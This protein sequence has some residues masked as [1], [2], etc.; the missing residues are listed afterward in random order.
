[1]VVILNRISAAIPPP[2]APGSHGGSRTGAAG[3]GL[4]EWCGAC[5]EV[6]IE[7]VG[8]ADG[9]GVE[10]LGRGWNCDS[11]GCGVELALGSGSNGTQPSPVNRI[12]GQARASRPR[13]VPVPG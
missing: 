6:E 12:S 10:G 7:M 11:S 3:A 1:M 5:G 8:S 4:G 2:T 9:G 13:T